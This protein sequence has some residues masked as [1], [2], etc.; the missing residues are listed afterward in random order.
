MS[1]VHGP[2]RIDYDAAHEEG[3]DRT[4]VCGAGKNGATIFAFPFGKLPFQGRHVVIKC[5]RGDGTGSYWFNNRDGVTVFGNRDGDLPDGGDYR[6]FTVLEDGAAYTVG[7]KNKPGAMRI[8]VNITNDTFYYTP[9]HYTRGKEL[10]GNTDRIN[11]DF[12]N[13]FYQ[14]VDVPFKRG[15]AIPE[16]PGF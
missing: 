11:A 1:T 12:V 3:A 10:K 15:D 2:I 14:V 16:G 4:R 8:V 7:A 9:T 6:E 13:P 5:L